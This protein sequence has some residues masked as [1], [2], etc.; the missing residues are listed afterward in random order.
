MRVLLFSLN[1]QYLFM[2][3]KFKREMLHVKYMIILAK[4]PWGEIRTVGNKTHWVTF[5]SFP[6]F[7]QVIDIN[8]NSG[9]RSPSHS[10][11]ASFLILWTWEEWGGYLE[12][13]WSEELSCY[14]YRRILNF[15]WRD[16][17][18]AGA[19]TLWGVNWWADLRDEKHMESKLHDLLL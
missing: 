10:S 8:Y 4:H 13:H 11:L 6:P 14:S 12:G 3:K 2:A 17:K 7:C 9:P 1:L 5:S 16:C 15:I 18:A 19:N